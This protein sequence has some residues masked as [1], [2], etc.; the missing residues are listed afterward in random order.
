MKVRVIFEREKI[1]KN[2][3]SGWGNSYLVGEEVLF[4]TGEKS[5]YILNNLKMLNVNILDVK[6]IV[7]SHN[8]WDHMDKKAL[9]FLDNR[10][11]T[12]LAC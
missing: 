7:I 1:N 2:F 6:T 8:H 10:L 3:F 11:K 4:D 5:E 9:L 12:A